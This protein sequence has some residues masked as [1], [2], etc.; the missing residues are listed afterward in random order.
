MGGY[1]VACYRWDGDFDHAVGFATEA[2][3]HAY[4]LAQAGDGCRYEVWHNGVRVW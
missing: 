1:G 4:V 2:D 3:A